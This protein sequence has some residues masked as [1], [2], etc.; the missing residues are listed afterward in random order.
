MRLNRGLEILANL[1]HRGAL[2]G[3]LYHR[4][5]IRPSR[6]FGPSVSAGPGL[7]RS[8]A[9][10]FDD[11]PSLETPRLL[12]Y[13]ASEGIRATF[14]QCGLNVLRHPEIARRVHAEGHEIG[15]HTFSHAR[16]PPQLRRQ[17]NWRT[18]AN[19][20]R[21]LAETQRILTSILGQPPTLFRP[22][23]GLRWFGLG[24]AMRR[25][26][27]LG[28]RWTAIGHD[29][30]WPAGRIA[31]H[32]LERSGPGGILCLHDGRDVQ[33]DVDLAPLLDAL[34]VIVPALKAE[35]YGFETVSELLMPDR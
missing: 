6:A 27:L 14:F 11:G 18:P 29:W 7:R 20:D 31:A 15:N 25:L 34:R 2:A 13:L 1:R 9:L 5:H 19:I 33:L 17:L 12:D 4:L 21:E 22:P 24:R 3:A 30:E 28:V 10:T 8:V 32:I 26:G 35:G 16:L 23:Y